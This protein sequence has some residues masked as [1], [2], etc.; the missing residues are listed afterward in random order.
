[1]SFEFL[2]HLSHYPE[3]RIEDFLSFF[4]AGGDG[5]GF[6]QM[7]MFVIPAFSC[8]QT[9]DSPKTSMDKSG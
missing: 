4:V 8:F 7:F 1:M 6:D 2:T 5:A 3:I 9:L